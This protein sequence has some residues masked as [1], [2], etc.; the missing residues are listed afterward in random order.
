MRTM[1]QSISPKNMG[2]LQCDPPVAGWI[3]YIQYLPQMLVYDWSSKLALLSCQRGPTFFN[4]L[5]IV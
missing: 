1:P 3:S 2:K 5:E 4:Y